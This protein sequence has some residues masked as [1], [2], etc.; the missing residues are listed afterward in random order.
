MKLLSGFTIVCLHLGLLGEGL[1]FLV[2]EEGPGDI[3]EN[4]EPSTCVWEKNPCPLHG[5]S[6][7]PDRM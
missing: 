1:L 6:P 4:T 2:I 3:P 5:L 7:R